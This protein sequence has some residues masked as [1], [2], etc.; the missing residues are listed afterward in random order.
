MIASLVDL[1]LNHGLSGSTHMRAELATMPLADCVRLFET[2]SKGLLEGHVAHFSAVLASYCRLVTAFIAAE[3]V[4]FARSL[5][6]AAQRLSDW[7]IRRAPRNRALAGQ[8]ASTT[9]QYFSMQIHTTLF[10]LLQWFPQGF[11]GTDRNASAIQRSPFVDVPDLSENSLLCLLAGD[12]QF[13]DIAASMPGLNATK[14]PQD[15]E[16]LKQKRKRG[17]GNQDRDSPPSTLA[18]SQT[19]ASTASSRANN[20]ADPQQPGDTF[21]WPCVRY[22]TKGGCTKKGD[23]CPN[24]YAHRLPANAKEANKISELIAKMGVPWFPRAQKAC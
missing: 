22:C 7:A 10:S 18:A 4:Y 21:D 11:D 19:Q 3:D 14:V 24:K 8:F 23:P 15:R 5:S 6:A 20:T 2:E 13:Q 16:Q 12:I 1:S 17:S 9:L